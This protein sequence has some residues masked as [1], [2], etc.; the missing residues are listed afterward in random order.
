MICFR[1]EFWD[2]HNQECK[3]D[4]QT[5]D[6]VIS[7]NNMEICECKY[8]KEV[9]KEEVDSQ[10]DEVVSTFYTYTLPKALTP[11]KTE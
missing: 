6:V 7:A 3:K 10:L 4:I 1:C 5:D 11:Q 9:S 2:Y 8:F